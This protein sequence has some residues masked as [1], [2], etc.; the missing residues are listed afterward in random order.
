MYASRMAVA[1]QGHETSNIVRSW[2]PRV[3][4]GGPSGTRFVYASRM[5]VGLG[6]LS[7]VVGHETSN[8]ARF[9]SPQVQEGVDLLERGLSL[10]RI[11]LA[12]FFSIFCGVNILRAGTTRLNT[13]FVSIAPSITPDNPACPTVYSVGR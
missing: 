2:S 7:M 9:W 12:C 6:T 4:E 5:A 11:A 13:S 3:Q 8:I 1:L 10:N